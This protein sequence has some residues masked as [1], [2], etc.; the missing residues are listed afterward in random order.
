MLYRRPYSISVASR[1]SLFPARGPSPSS[2]YA[3]RSM[4]SWTLLRSFASASY[5]AASARR[6]SG[7]SGGPWS[8]VVRWVMRA[9]AP[10]RSST[11]ARTYRM[12][13]IAG[14]HLDH[15]IWLTPPHFSYPVGIDQSKLPHPRFRRHASPS[16]FLF[17][18][19][20]MY[21]IYRLGI[22]ALFRSLHSILQSYYIFSGHKSKAKGIP[23]LRT[24]MTGEG[25]ERGSMVSTH[26]V[27]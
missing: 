8:A 25:T 23:Y 21:H 14:F 17:K 5:D 22:F 1:S 6:S 27:C 4:T 13:S 19:F 2:L 11:F 9:T 26:T 12:P 7:S 24:M 20:F 10:R 15:M 16:P 3:M 18:L